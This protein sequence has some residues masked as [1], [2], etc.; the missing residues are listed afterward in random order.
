LRLGKAFEPEFGTASHV[1]F[2]LQ[3]RIATVGF[4]EFSLRFSKGPDVNDTVHDDFHLL[5]RILVR[6][7]RDRQFA[8]VCKG[9]KAV[10]DQ[11]VNGRR[12]QNSQPGRDTSD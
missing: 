2:S 12:Y 3:R 11:T 10:V 7:G 5:H 8:S 6:Q 1:D 9:N 4:E